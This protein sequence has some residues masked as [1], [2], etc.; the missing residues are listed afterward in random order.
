MCGSSCLYKMESYR[1]SRVAQ[2]NV[3]YTPALATAW[4]FRFANRSPYYCAFNVNT[5]YEGF[6]YGRT[7][8]SFVRHNM[9]VD[10]ETP[11]VSSD[12]GE[13]LCPQPIISRSSI[14]K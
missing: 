10:D 9:E 12:A 5:R 1:T 7:G 13:P 4:A 14:L 8:I 11:L 2:R 6:A 3:K